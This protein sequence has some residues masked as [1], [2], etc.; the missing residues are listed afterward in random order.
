MIQPYSKLP[1][2]E[3]LN[4]KKDKYQIYTADNLTCVIPSVPNLSDAMYIEETCNNY[5]TLLS[6]LEQIQSDLADYQNKGF[7]GLDTFYD[8][9]CAN[10]TDF[11]DFMSKKYLNY[12]LYTTCNKCFS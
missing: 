2:K 6:I 8:R 10:V 12:E 9:M 4:K 7:E 5:P 1:W 11:E 3:L